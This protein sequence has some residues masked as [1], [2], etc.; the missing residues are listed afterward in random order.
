MS[1]RDVVNFLAGVP[2][3]AGRILYK[4]L[5]AFPLFGELLDTPLKHQTS[6]IREMAWT[7]VLAT[8]PIWFFPIAAT[9]LFRG[10]P[11]IQEGIWNSITQGDLYLYSAAI[12]GPLM[13]ALTTTYGEWDGPNTTAS[14]IGKWAILFPYGT[15]FIS[16]SFVIG[17]ICTFFFGFIR[18]DATGQISAILNNDTL[19][20]ISIWVYLVANIA[21]LLVIAYRNKLQ[22][23]VPDTRLEEHDFVSAFLKGLS[24][25]RN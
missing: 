16:I 10:A 24:D 6:A 25:E 3:G 12:V 1:Y 20:Q 22:N 13:F 21:M 5:R 7:T 15:W 11:T 19:V 2:R 18:Y 23:I 17:A 9:A 4:L 14:R 8:L